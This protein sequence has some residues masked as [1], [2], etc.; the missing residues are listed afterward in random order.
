MCSHACFIFH[1]EHWAVSHACLASIVLVSKVNDSARF[2]FSLPIMRVLTDSMRKR[3][4]QSTTLKR[5]ASAPS[6]RASPELLSS[7]A[8]APPKPRTLKQYDSWGSMD[9][10]YWSTYGRPKNP[11]TDYLQCQVCEGTYAPHQSPGFECN[12]CKG[13]KFDEKR[14]DPHDPG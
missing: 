12:H 1:L 10:E 4:A 5:P 9:S 14:G 6:E 7:I 2:E 3:P 8:M 11:F 13:T